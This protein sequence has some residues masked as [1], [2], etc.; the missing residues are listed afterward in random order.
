MSIG[1]RVRR[2]RKYA[3][4]TQTQLGKAVGVKQATISDLEKGDSRS[5]AYLI[6]IAHACGVDSRWL[7]TGKGEMVPGAQEAGGQYQVEPR[8]PSE[9]DYALIPQLS[10]RASNGD[11]YLNHHVEVT[12]GLAFKRTWL[13]KNHLKPENLSVIYAEGDSMEPNIVDGDVL[14][15]DHNDVHP[16]S[17]T[18]Y[19]LRRPDNS[20]SIKRLFQRVTG[21]WVITSDNPDKARHPDEALGAETVCQVPIIGKVVWRGGAMA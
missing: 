12:G 18:V 8:T 21:E 11:G 6:Q 10:A 4:L 16:I 14:V 17:G 1:E 5:S 7:A 3:K 9:E 2:A 19:A 15:I 20:I 13:H